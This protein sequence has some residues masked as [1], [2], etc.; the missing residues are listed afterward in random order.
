[1]G[2]PR[3]AQR[4][5]GQQLQSDVNDYFP[6][7]ITIR[8]GD[9]IRWIPSGFHNVD[10]P[11]RGQR[12]TPLIVP[13]GQTVSNVLDEAGAPFWFNGPPPQPLLGFNPELI[14]TSLFGRRVTYNPSERLQTGLPLQPR[15]RPVTVRF[16][17]TGTIRYFCDVHPGMNGIVRVIARRDRVPSRQA[18]RRAVRRQIQSRLAIARD[19]ARF[20]PPANVIRLGVAGRGG[21][22]RFAF[23]PSQLSVPSGT[24]IQF[25]MSPGSYEV[26]TATTGPGNP[27]SEPQSFLG[28]LAGTFETPQVDPRAIYSSEPPGAPAATL[29]PGLHGNTFW[30]SG[31]LD[32]FP[33]TPNPAA[34]TVRIGGPPGTTYT[35]YCLI[36]PFMRATITAT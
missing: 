27:E 31:V 12:I 15:P 13:T 17:R 6:H 11:A 5:F 8:R 28:Q 14:Q 2:T 35:F 25:Q 23:Q 7:R 34:N 10:I 9:S 24:G 3:E 33:N 18:D 1:M 19:L 22:E 32:R 16:R 26:H 30:N 29:A 21:V 20:R 4:Q 36:H